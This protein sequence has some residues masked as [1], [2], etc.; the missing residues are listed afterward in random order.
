MLAAGA[1]LCPYMILAPLGA[2]GVGEVYRARNAR[3]KH[4]VAITASP[5][6]YASDMD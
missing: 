4:D 5:A 6:A 2:G 1:T 3:L